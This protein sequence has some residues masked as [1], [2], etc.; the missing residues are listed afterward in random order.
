M[1]TVFENYVTDIE[2]DGKKVELTLWDTA[3]QED[4]DRLRPLS[5]PDT[6]VVLMCFSVDQPDSLENIAE[7]VYTQIRAL[8][9]RLTARHSGTRRS[10][11]FAVGYPRYSSPPSSISVMMSAS[12]PT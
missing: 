9:V 12:L 6:N 10:C 1:P 11:T 7:K 3:G 2:V 8:I 4:Y 5:Y